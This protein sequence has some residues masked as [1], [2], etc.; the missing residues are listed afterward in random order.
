ML[1]TEQIDRDLVNAMKQRE[2]LRLSVLRMLKSALKLKQVETGAALSDEQAQ[3]ILRTLVKQRREAAEM[4]A[5]GGRG[6]LAQKELDEIKIVDSYLPA[7]ATDADLEAAVAAAISETA[8]T[9]PKDLGRVMKAAVA[10]L[11]GK[12]VDGKRL[13]ELV[14]A[15]LGQ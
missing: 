9:T 3:A 2:E 7:A 4:F 8:A 14:K 1:L 12:T 10:R 13:S 11:V 15:R 6:E 5:Q